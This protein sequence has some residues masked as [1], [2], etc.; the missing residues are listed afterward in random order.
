MTHTQYSSREEL[1]NAITHGLGALLGLLAGIVLI[2]LAA[3]TGDPWR[4]VGA[5]VFSLSLVMLYTASA[6]YHAAPAGPAKFRLEIIDHCAI[7]I[8]IAGTYTPFTLVTLRGPWGWGLFAVVWTLAVVG[9]ALK[10]VFTTRFKLL[11]TLI[12]IGMGWLVIVA[13]GPM[14]AALPFSTLALLVAGGVAYTAGTL[15]YHNQRVPFAHAIWHLFVIAGSV[16]HYLAV[17][18]VVA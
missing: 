11:S 18:A 5:T 3:M 12:Y 15:F 2:V 8:L 16:L 1:A 13:V 10:L 14:M 7:F 17:A 6:V 4:I 9:V